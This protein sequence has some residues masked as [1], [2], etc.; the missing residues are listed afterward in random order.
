MFHFG[1]QLFIPYPLCTPPKKYR[2]IFY[3]LANQRDL[4]TSSLKAIENSEDFKDL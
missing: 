2:D 4:V 3:W 1:I